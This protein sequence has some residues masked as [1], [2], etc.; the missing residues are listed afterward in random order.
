MGTLQSYVIQSFDS[1]QFNVQ[2]VGDASSEDMIDL[3]Y[4]SGLWR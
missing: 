4:M 3:C 2:F 1:S